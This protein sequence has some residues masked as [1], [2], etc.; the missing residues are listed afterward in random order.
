MAHRRIKW[1]SWEYILLSLTTHPLWP[2]HHNSLPV[3]HYTPQPPLQPDYI[4]HHPLQLCYAFSYNFLY[5]KVYSCDW[6]LANGRQ[7]GETCAISWSDL[8][9]FGLLLLHLLFSLFCGLVDKNRC[10][11]SSV[12]KNYRS[13]NLKKPLEVAAHRS[14]TFI[15]V[16]YENE[17]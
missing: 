15:W 13:S 12:L 1:E 17:K 11:R 14:R 10:L 5:S 16:F 7:V 2:I 8:L 4:S 3:L 6:S 9:K